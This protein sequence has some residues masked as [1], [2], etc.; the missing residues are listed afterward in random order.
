MSYVGIASKAGTTTGN[1][2]KLL[3]TGHACPSVSRRLGTTSANIT[4]FINGKVTPS[5]AKVLG[6]TTPHAQ[7]LRD[8]I[9]KE[10]SIGIILGLACGISEKK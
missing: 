6:A 8:E 9:S 4:A 3:H 2:K 7:L 10:A 1:I 5:I